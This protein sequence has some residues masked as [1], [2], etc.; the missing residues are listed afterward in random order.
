MDGGA[1]IPTRNPKEE[2]STF[3]EVP[4]AARTRQGAVSGRAQRPIARPYLA[5]P[6][7]R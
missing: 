6:P 7:K 1:G 4:G 5:S 2:T 3:V